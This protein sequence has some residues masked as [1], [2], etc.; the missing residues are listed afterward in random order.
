VR[1]RKRV[2]ARDSVSRLRAP[3][4]A[5][6]FIRVTIGFG[7]IAPLMPTLLTNIFSYFSAAGAPVCFPGTACLTASAL[8]LLA[9]GLFLRA[10]GASSLADD[11]PD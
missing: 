7:I 2:G 3:G 11:V 8:G 10:V 4:G 5:I 9:I 6:F 1:E